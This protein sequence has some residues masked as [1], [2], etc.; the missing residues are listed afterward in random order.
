[1]GLFFF[2]NNVSQKR[3]SDLHF[4]T[5]SY[6]SGY[7]VVP[8]A[9]EYRFSL[10]CSLPVLLPKIYFCP[11]CTILIADVYVMNIH[12]ILGLQDSSGKASTG[13]TA[14]A[15]ALTG[16]GRQGEEARLVTMGAVGY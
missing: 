6:S 8:R 12:G 9:Q 4:K 1:M 5:T 14:A 2:F 11:N 7:S 10:S 16:Y 13:G 3:R 15:I